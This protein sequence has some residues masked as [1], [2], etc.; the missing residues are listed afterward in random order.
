MGQGE[1]AQVKYR[2][3]TH[4]S[5]CEASISDHITPSRSVSLMNTYIPTEAAM[6]LKKPN[7]CHSNVLCK[8]LKF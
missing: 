1:P 2:V 5:K 6:S 3:A 4:A 8:E 7:T